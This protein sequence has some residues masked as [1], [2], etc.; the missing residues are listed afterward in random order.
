MSVT[1]FTAFLW[2]YSVVATSSVKSVKQIVE[3]NFSGKMAATEKYIL[4]FGYHFKLR[5]TFRIFCI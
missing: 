4:V 3:A 5:I 2:F 1:A